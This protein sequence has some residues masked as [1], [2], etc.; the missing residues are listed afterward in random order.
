MAN[1]D[2]N[3]LSA[4]DAALVRDCEFEA[5]DAKNIAQ[6]LAIGG[7]GEGESLCSLGR[8]HDYT[9]YSGD[10]EDNTLNRLAWSVIDDSWGV[11]CARAEY[12]VRV[13]DIFGDVS[14]RALDFFEQELSDRGLVMA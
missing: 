9:P 4:A 14:Q 12:K 10:V 3:K 11:D 1:I 6:D 5:Q 7:N 8:D 13:V 2:L